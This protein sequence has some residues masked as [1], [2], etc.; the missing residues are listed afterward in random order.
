MTYTLPVGFHRFSTK[1]FVNY[2]LN[3][4]YSEGFADFDEI[5]EAGRRIRRFEDSQEVFAELAER[6]RK[7]GRKRHSA[8]YWRAAE[9]LAKP[10]T[11]AREEITRRHQDAFYEAFA[12][13]GI[14][15][16][17]VPYEGSFL[18][19]ARL[20]PGTPGQ[21][22]S[23]KGTVLI[24][25]G[26]DSFIEEFYVF[27]RAFA[28]AGFEVIAFDGPGQGASLNLYHVPHTHD[29]E[30]P[31]GAVLDHFRK[32]DVTLLG[33]SFGGYWCVRAAAFEQRVKRLIVDPPFYDLLEKEGPLLK[34]TVGWMTR[35]RRFLNWSVETR[36]RAIPLLAHVANQVR[37][38]NQSPEAEPAQIVDWL[39]QMNKNHV[40]SERVTQDVLL[41]CGEKDRFQP[42]SLLK[43]Q[44]EALVNARSVETRVF[45][46]AENAASH[47]QMGNLQLALDQMISWLE[48]VGAQTAPR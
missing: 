9:F 37:H 38:I 23:S 3:R 48:R 5:A 13:E 8:T 32:D 47:C 6:A 24:H 20:S 28:D 15:R 10:F 35:H 16:A 2:Q 29:W 18:S 25:G 31:V 27:W 1:G 43:L 41:L 12:E 40:H 39:L 26:F 36:T 34:G 4:W 14:E 33:I 30:K 11:G 46:E 22:V 44:K 21:P 42:P 7:Q 45:T 19:A 17:L